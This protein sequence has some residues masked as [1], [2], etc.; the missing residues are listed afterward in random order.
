MPPPPKKTPVIPHLSAGSGAEKWKL[1]ITGKAF[2]EETKGFKVLSDP[3]WL[4]MLLPVGNASA[5]S[6]SVTPA[7][8]YDTRV[9]S[10]FFFLFGDVVFSEY[11]CTTTVFSLSG[12]YVARFFLPDGGF[13]PCDHGLDFLYQLIM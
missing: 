8:A 11:F 13:L 12:E 3:V 4:A 6:Q 5:E 2:T 7:M 1:Y 10:F 9:S